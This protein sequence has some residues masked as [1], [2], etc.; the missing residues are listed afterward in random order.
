MQEQDFRGMAAKP[1]WFRLFSWCVVLISP[2]RDSFLATFSE[3]CH[4][5]DRTGEEGLEKLSGLLSAATGHC[6]ALAE[7]LGG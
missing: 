5:S 1:V 6:H 7:D 2:C 3:G 4:C